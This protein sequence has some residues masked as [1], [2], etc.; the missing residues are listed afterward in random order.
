MRRPKVRPEH[1]AVLEE[2]LTLAEA[3]RQYHIRP[4]SLSYAIDA[5]LIAAKRCGRA[6]LISVASLEDYFKVR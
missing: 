1:F 5:N 3:A 6:V 4:A 2:V